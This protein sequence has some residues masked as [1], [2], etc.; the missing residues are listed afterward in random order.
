MNGF[1]CSS[2]ISHLFII[3][4]L[5]KHCF[6][7]Y[8]ILWL[9][10]RNI[11]LVFDPVPST[12]LPKFM[13][14]HKWWELS[15]CLLL[16]EVIFGPH[17]RMWVGCQKNQPCYERVGNL[18]PTSLTLERKGELEV[19]LV[20]NGQWFNRCQCNEA[21]IN[22]QKDKVQRASGLVNTWRF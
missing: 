10:I 4:L 9:I 2:W 20:T 15:K 8:V 6:N 5:H 21:S 12:E 16:W 14:F 17:Q 18:S 19:E 13:E 1:V 22:T 11:Y 3:H 7:I